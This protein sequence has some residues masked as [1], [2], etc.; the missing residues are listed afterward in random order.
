[1]V[2]G[3]LHTLISHCFDFMGI[4]PS[5]M[6][7]HLMCIAYLNERKEG[8]YKRSSGQTSI[9][10]QIKDHKERNKMRIRKLSLLFVFVVAVLAL[11]TGLLVSHAQDDLT[12][13]FVQTGSE[14]GWRTDFT[15]AM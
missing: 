1:M 10:E 2:N 6:Q 15:N 13:G 14:S 7:V 12:V 5:P 11:S 3:V 9:Y 8:L 4:R